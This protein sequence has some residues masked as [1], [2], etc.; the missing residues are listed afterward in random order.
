MA[1]PEIID[2]PADQWTLVAT[3][4]TSGLV[5]IFQGEGLKWLQTFRDTGETAPT[6]TS[7]SVQFNEPT[8]LISSNAAIDVYVWPNGD[9]GKVRVDL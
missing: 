8:E 9:A 7:D 2:C 4:V 3:A 5:H 6:D 1:N